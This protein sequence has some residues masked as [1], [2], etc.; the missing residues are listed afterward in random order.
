MRGLF[1]TMEGPDGSGKSTQIE[2]LAHYLKYK[3]YEVI[4]TR[5][6]GGTRIGEKIRKLILDKENTEMDRVTEALLY[7]ASRAQHVA[8]VIAPSVQAGKVVICD[9][10][11][12]SSIV[13]QG[14]GRALGIEVVEKI[15]QIAIKNIFPHIT[16][17]FKLCPEI[18]LARKT[19]QG[20]KDRLEQETLDFHQ[21][22]FEGYQQLEAL[23]PQRIV[24]IDA[25]KSIEDIHQQMIERVKIYI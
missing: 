8:E 5:E 24:A 23:Y 12:D 7:A 10:F 20:E 21:R 11:V 16:F 17:L 18:G 15:N 22:V 4:V 13:Y 6:P 19:Q 25:S 9:R 3:G 2:K 14:I 1:I